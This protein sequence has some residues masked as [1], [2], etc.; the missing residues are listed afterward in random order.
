MLTRHSARP[1]PG[2]PH[3]MVYTPYYD[4]P[5]L[6][7]NELG[8]SHEGKDEDTALTRHACSFW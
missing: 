7:G 6:G 2:H 1:V 5:M 4:N 8:G 3:L